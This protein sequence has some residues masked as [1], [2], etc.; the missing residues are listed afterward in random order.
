MLMMTGNAMATGLWVA[1]AN[2]NTLIEFQGKLKKIHRTLN[3]TDLDGPSTIVFD[4]G[5]NLWVTNFNINTI[6][7]YTRSQLQKIKKHTPTPT[8]IISQ[9]IGANL[10]GPEGMAFDSSGNLWVGAENGQV[11][12]EYT[13]A[14]IDSPCDPECRVHR[15]VQLALAPDFRFSR[16]SVGE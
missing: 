11:I 10:S 2:A 12:V 1:N 9:D 4:G 5:G 8:V 14:Q 15:R 7:E 16:Q 13:S 3:D 6:F